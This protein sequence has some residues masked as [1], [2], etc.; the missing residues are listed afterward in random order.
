MKVAVMR[1]VPETGDADIW[2]F[3]LTSGA[4]TPVTNDQADDNWPVWSPDG[5]QVA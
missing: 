2:T 4:G 3:D 1:V 5:G